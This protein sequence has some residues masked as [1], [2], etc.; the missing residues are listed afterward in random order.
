[1][2]GGS[3]SAPRNN[4]PKPSP[5]LAKKLCGWVKTRSRVAYRYCSSWTTPSQLKDLHR[6]DALPVNWLH[7]SAGSEDKPNRN[8]IIC[9]GSIYKVLKWYELL[10]NYPS[11]KKLIHEM[12][13]EEFLSIKEGN[14]DNQLVHALVE[15]WWPSTHTLYF[16]YEELG[17]T[18]LDFVMLTALP[19]RI[20]INLPYDNK[21]SNVGEAEKMFPGITSDD[22]KFGNIT[23]AGWL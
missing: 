23:S 14:S 13:F 8:N 2:L 3:S 21:Y 15:R 6:V 9:R 22:M 10:A 16:P 19:C 5:M 4:I 12:G 1:M 7:I 11:I 20:G 17:F 18:L